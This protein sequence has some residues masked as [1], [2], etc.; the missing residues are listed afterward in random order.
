MSEEKQSNNDIDWAEQNRLH[1]EW[2]AQ[3]KSEYQ[4]WVSI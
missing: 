4:G 1:R 2:I 3:G